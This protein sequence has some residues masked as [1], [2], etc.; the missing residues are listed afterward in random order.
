MNFKKIIC[1]AIAF[2]ALSA[3][4]AQAVETVKVW[5][6]GPHQEQWEHIRKVLKP[7]GVNIELVRFSDYILP[8]R[9]LND[10]ETDLNSFQTIIFLENANKELGL[11]LVPI[12][13]TVFCP[14]GL[15]WQKH[16]SPS[17]FQKG[18]RIAIPNDPT[19]GGRALKLLEAAGLIKVNPDKGF[20]P[21][22]RDITENRLDLQIYEVDAANTAGLLPDV[23][24]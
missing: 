3:T 21:A 4:S 17:E 22:V 18:D 11:K 8:N 1:S 10:G 12:G 2:A 9:S 16:K 15:F 7:E 5:V 6:V 14:L 13:D 23:A 19:Q 24:G 20:L